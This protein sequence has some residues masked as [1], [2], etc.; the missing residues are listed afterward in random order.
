MLK[1]KFRKLFWIRF[2]IGIS[3]SIILLFICIMTLTIP[4]GIKKPI[5]MVSAFLLVFLTYLSLD[6]F[7]IFELAITETGIEK[8]NLINRKKEYFPFNMISSIQL[9]KVSYRNSK[10]QISDGHHLSI[11]IFKNGIDMVISPDH[12][13][14]YSE[15]ISEIKRHIK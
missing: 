7:K 11:L 1:S 15:I 3:L 13:E 2:G 5:F 10:S 4:N 14:N 12:F 6:I 9:E 8:I